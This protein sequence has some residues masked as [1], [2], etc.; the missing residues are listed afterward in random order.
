MHPQVRI[1]MYALLV[2]IDNRQML[3]Q[4]RW[5]VNLII[6]EIQLKKFRSDRQIIPSPKLMINITLLVK[7]FKENR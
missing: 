6:F 1:L 2:K 7:K 5:H 4:A 3:R